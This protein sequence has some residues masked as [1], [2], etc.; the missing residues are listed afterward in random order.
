MD[1]TIRQVTFFGSAAVQAVVAAG[2]ILQADWARALWP[3]EE[4][5]LSYIF[6][7]SV[8][9]ALAAGGLMTGLQ[10]RWRAAL[11]S[12]IAVAVLFL[13]LAAVMLGQGAGGPVPWACLATGLGA[14][15]SAWDVA[16][17]PPLDAPLP[18]WPRLSCVIF[19]LALIGA[20]GALV[21]GAPRVFPWPLKP[22]SAMGFGVI[23]LG[24]SLSYGLSALW[25][26]RAMA[27]VGLTGFLVYDLVL[28]PPFLAHFQTVAPDRLTSLTVYVA[29]LV[30]SLVLAIWFLWP[31]AGGARP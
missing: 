18:A 24:L 31:R 14:A 13:A 3:W 6:L 12:L 19:A 2:F 25:N 27:A 11:P 9:A 21:L 10:G 26:G 7:G 8:L 23:F 1:T 22:E 29:V 30:Y 15:W 20:G 4:G 5:R 28:L 17:D 16:R